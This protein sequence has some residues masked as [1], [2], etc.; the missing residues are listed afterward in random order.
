MWAN[1]CYP[2]PDAPEL[3]GTEPDVD[4]LEPVLRV[5]FDKPGPAGAKVPVERYFPAETYP[6][7]RRRCLALQPS[8]SVGGGG[9][10]RLLPRVAGLG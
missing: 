9:H 5:R 2:V 4:A 6:Q 10:P 7:P 1:E 8:V 3:L